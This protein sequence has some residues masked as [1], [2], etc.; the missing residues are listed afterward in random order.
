[1]KMQAQWLVAA[2]PLTTK[3]ISFFFSELQLE[4]ATLN[5]LL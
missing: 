3:L 1:M 2:M 5:V 4:H